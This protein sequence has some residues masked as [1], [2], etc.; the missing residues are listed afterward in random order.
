[1]KRRTFLGVAGLAGSTLTLG[2]FQVAQDNSEN[3][4]SEQTENDE[5]SPQNTEENNDDESLFGS[6]EN[7]SAAHSDPHDETDTNTTGETTNE[8]A[9]ET[10]N[11]T[12]DDRQ[13]RP[14]ADQVEPDRSK[15]NNSDTGQTTDTKSLPADSVSVTSNTKKQGRTYVATGK[16]TN[17]I[18]ETID[19]VDI[20]VKWLDENESVIG[21]SITT[22]RNIPP[23][24]SEKF[25]A[26]AS[27]VDLRGEPETIDGTAYP[28]QY[29]N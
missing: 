25:R 2:C 10:T 15:Y 23:N 18:N 21:T 3:S 27:V 24:G 6:D 16:V 11:E 5:N 19:F 13:K 17:E 4:D 26:T 9:N 28:Q 7:D 1:M 29:V 8:T 12:T 14:T 20:E 22:V